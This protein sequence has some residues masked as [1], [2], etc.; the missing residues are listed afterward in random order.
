MFKFIVLVVEINHYRVKIFDK[1]D[2]AIL[3]QEDS[4][5]IPLPFLS[6]PTTKMRCNET[7]AFEQKRIQNSNKNCNKNLRLK[8]QYITK[9]IS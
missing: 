3:F 1:T 9:H 4:C 7:S 5:P 2:A 6:D 8:W